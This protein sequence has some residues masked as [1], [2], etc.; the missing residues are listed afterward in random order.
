VRAEVVHRALWQLSDEQRTAITL[1]DL[2]GF[3]AREVARMTGS[4]RGTVLSRVHRGR[5]RLAQI[6][7]KEVERLEA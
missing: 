1:M 4:P 5:K 2:N 7:S 3:T 6:L